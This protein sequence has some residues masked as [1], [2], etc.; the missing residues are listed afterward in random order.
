M[1]KQ[2]EKDRFAAFIASL[3]QASYLRPI[4]EDIR[5]DVESAMTCD[6]AFIDFA[7]R[8]EEQRAH[9]KEVAELQTYRDARRAEIPHL[10]RQRGRLTDGLAAL[11]SEARRLA[12]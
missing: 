7:A 1:T 2:E 4:L 9:R 5:P 11:R 6:L 10:E 12:S 8:V 3:P